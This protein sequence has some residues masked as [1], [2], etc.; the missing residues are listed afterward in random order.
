MS[1]GF[2]RKNAQYKDGAF[3]QTV[4]T[5]DQTERSLAVAVG[6]PDDDTTPLWNEGAEWSQLQTTITPKDAGN[7]L[8]LEL[9]VFG[10]TS[11]GNGGKFTVSVFKDPTGSDA[12]IGAGYDFH[13]YTGIGGDSFD[14]GY[15]A[16]GLKLPTGTTSP[17]TFKVRVAPGAGTGT[18]Y[19]NACTSGGGNLGNMFTSYLKVTEVQGSI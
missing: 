2:T 5:V 1:Q 17:I 14:A 6:I 19:V 7:T 11:A 4:M 9:S 15:V 3:V 12:C 18:V 13:N 10:Q 8:I 16:I